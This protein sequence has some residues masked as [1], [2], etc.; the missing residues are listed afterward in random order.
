MAKSSN[1]TVAIHLK[2][3]FRNPRYSSSCVTYIKKK[4]EIVKRLFQN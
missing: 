1:G 3:P 4:E 2:Q